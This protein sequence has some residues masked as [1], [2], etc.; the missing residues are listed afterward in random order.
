[1]S[2]RLN[3]RTFLKA[4]A[5]AISGPAIL[6]GCAT[7]RHGRPAPSERI[8][9]GAIGLGWQGPE[10]LGR[11]L[12]L[13]DVQVVAVCDVDQTHLQRTKEMVDRTYENTDCAAYT[14]F[15]ELIARR[16]LDAVSIA[17]PDHWHAIPSIMAAE[18]GLD[19]Y[20]EKPLAHTLVEG[21]AICDAVRRN[22]RIWQTGSWQRSVEN[23][24]RAA[25]LVR[26][27]RLGKVSHVEV[28]LG[29]G[30]DDYAGTKEQ[31]AEQPPPP[32]L[33]YDRWLGP[34]PVSPYVPARLHKN[35]RWVM[36]YGGGRIMDWVGHHLD[37]AHWGLGL[38]HTGPIRVEGTG[39]IPR[40]GVWDAPTDYDCTCEYEGGL[41]IRIGSQFPMGAKWY[42]ERG[43]LFVTR[44]ELVAEPASILDEVIGDDE[45]RLYKSTN[46]Y[47]NF[48]E[49]VK[50]RKQTIT[51]AETAHRSASV[52][53]LCD[54][55]LYTGRKIRWN[56]KSE[57]ILGD[58]A[59]SEMLSPHYREPWTLRL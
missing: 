36:D 8:V 26:N 50:N 31:T 32:E 14:R 28:G 57:E 21:R 59:A 55:A 27:G 1:M 49:C 10:N 40:G 17:L 9:M 45:I 2:S 16:D 3:R 53:H 41:V 12:Q 47:A 33:D 11:F 51:P 48:V 58:P 37:I 52:G 19:V 42:G 7:D 5:A 34:A 20:G 39:V 44:G 54:I 18:A 43:W 15:E 23:F 4:S 13:K 22:K 30:Y 25:E 24:H 6:A 38:D 29:Q 35:W 46:H 56:P